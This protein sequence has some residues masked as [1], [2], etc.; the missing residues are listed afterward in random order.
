MDREP[1]RD[2]AGIVICFSD[3][4]QASGAFHSANIG[5]RVTR[6]A[7]VISSNN[8]RADGRL[9]SAADLIIQFGGRR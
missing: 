9:D 7:V 5:K 6:R 8:I 3:F 4:C 2:V 1:G